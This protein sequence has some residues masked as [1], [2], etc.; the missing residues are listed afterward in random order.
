MASATSREPRENSSFSI[1]PK[2]PDQKI[3]AGTMCTVRIVTREQRPISMVIPALKSL[4]G[5]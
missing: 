5:V 3:K 2:G 1:C 4:L